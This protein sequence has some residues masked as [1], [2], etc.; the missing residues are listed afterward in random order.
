MH[1]RRACATGQYRVAADQPL[2]DVEAEFLEIASDGQIRVRKQDGTEMAIAQQD[3]SPTDQAFVTKIRAYTTIA[4]VVAIL[5]H[6][7]VVVGIIAVGYLAFQQRQDGNWCGDAVP[8]ASLH[9]PDDGARGPRAA[10]RHARVGRL[11]LPAS[12]GGRHVS[13]PGDRDHL[14]SDV[15]AA[16]V[17]QFL[18]AARAAA[19]FGGSGVGVGGDGLDAGLRFA[20]RRGLLAVLQEDVRA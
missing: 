4:K 6:L 3:L 7:A 10:D 13:R 14:L 18:L 19:V 20:G 11:L 8:D 9:V 1:L 5:S 2:V 15:S 12:A 17:V 16:V